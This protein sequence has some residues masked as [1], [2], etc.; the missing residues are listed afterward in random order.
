MPA[1]RVGCRAQRAGCVR[2]YWP[3]WA[4]PRADSRSLRALPF[5]Y[6]PAVQQCRSG[7]WR[8]VIRLKTARCHREQKPNRRPAC[9]RGRQNRGWLT[10]V[11]G[12]TAVGPLNW[13]AAQS[14]SVAS[15]LPQRA[16][17]T[18]WTCIGA[19]TL[20]LT[21]VKRRNGD[22]GQM[23]Y[24]QGNTR[25]TLPLGPNSSLHCSAI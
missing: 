11:E 23:R 5:R 14:V 6:C 21:D 17:P 25:A 2:R 1:R 16:G 18:I 7:R 3:S 24:K 22:V 19:G 9:T 20:L 12:Q 8:A 4:C 10:A 13:P 15:G